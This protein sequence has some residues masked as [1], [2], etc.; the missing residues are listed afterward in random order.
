M[1]ECEHGGGLQV[2]VDQ[3]WGPGPFLPEAGMAASLVRLQGKWSEAQV[4]F[5]SLGDRWEKTGN[6]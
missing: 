5:M 6:A 4:D 1:G 3:G 2:A